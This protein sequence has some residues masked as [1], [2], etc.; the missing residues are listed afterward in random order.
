MYEGCP[1][2]IPCQV[3]EL[4]VPVVTLVTHS[5]NNGEVFLGVPHQGRGDDEKMI[6]WEVSVMRPRNDWSHRQL[7]VTKIVFHGRIAI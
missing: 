7:A 2:E 1:S 4:P 3:I 5:A 6:P